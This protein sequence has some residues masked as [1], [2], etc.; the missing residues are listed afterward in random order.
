MPTKT[1]LSFTNKEDDVVIATDRTVKNGVGRAA[2]SLHTTDTPCSIWSVL[3]VDGRPSQISSYRAELFG[4]L[5]ALLLL[6]QLLEVLGT[7]DSG[8]MV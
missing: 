5:G 6:Y 8:A 2:Y 3:P 1:G 7:I 4:M